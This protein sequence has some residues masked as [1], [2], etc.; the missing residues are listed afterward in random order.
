MET[1]ETPFNL[2]ELIELF[3]T[4]NHQCIFIKNAQSSFCY[5]NEHFIQFMGLKNLNH[6]RSLCD[7]D[8]NKNKKDT[9]LYREHDNY[10]LDEDKTLLVNEVISPKHNQPIVKTMTGKLYPLFS[11]SEQANYVLGV[12]TPESKFLK[13]DFDTLFSLTQ[14]ELGEL[15]IRRSYAVNLSFGAITISKM[16][17]CILVQ[18]LKGCHAGQMAKKLQ[19]K[20]T[21]AESYI[22]NIKNKLAVSTKGELINQVINEKLLQQI[23]L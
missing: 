4:S 7:Y 2:G 5:G 15:L 18:L 8:I 11:Q 10:I 21:T 17:I 23:V 1:V 22:A 20:Q 6:L 9:E 16:E 3:D 19:I 14:E 12:V 13:L